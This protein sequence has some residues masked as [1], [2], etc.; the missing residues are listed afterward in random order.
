MS[1]F[2]VRSADWFPSRIARTVFGAQKG[3]RQVRL[4]IR[5]RK[6]L[7]LRN[8]GDVRDA[9]EPRMCSSNMLDEKFVDAARRPS[10]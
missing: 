1:C 9:L 8:L 10:W 2:S 6:L 7:A 4:D 5:P 3:K